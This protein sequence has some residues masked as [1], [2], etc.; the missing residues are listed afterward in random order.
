MASSFYTGRRFFASSGLMA[1]V[2]PLVNRKMATTP[3]SS[4]LTFFMIS[5]A[6]DCFLNTERIPRPFYKQD[7]RVLQCF[8]AKI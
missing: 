3:L 8:F 7:G 6:I 5:S 4:M 1:L 2:T